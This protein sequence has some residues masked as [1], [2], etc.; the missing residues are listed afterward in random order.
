MRMRKRFSKWSRQSTRMACLLAACGLLYACKDEF[1]L[2]DEKPTWLNSSIY[3]SLQEGI[4][5]SDDGKHLTFNTYLRL[6]ADK[7]VNPENVRPLTDVLN[8][9]GSKTVFVADDEAWDQFFKQNALLPET[10]PWHTATS[11]ENLSVSQK[12]LLIHTSMLNNAIVMENLASSE[13]SN[14]TTPVRG[15]YMRRFTDVELTD[16]VAFD[17]PDKLPHSY[18]GVDKDYWAR[19]REEDKGGIYLVKDNTPSMMLHFTSEHM[20]RNAVTDEDF[21]IIMGRERVT[22]DVHIYDAL[23][24]EK[25]Q[26]CENGYVNVTE[27]VLKPLANMA[28]VIRENGRTNIFSHILDRFCAPFYEPDVTLAYKNVLKARGIEWNDRDSVFVKRYFSDLSY[29]H[30]GW[31]VEPGPDGTV[32]PYMPY[33]DESSKDIIPSLK[34]DPGWNGYYAD[35]RQEKD[36]AAIFAPSDEALWKYFTEGGG[37]QLIETYGDPTK[38]YNSVED[39]Y[40]NIDQIPLGTLYA[41]VG[42]H[43]QRSFVTTVPSKMTKILEPVT[44]DQ[45]FYAEDIDKIDTCLLACNGAVYVMNGIYA[46]GDYTSVTSPAFISTTNNIM[47]WA[48]YNGSK[49]T[50]VEADY[51]GLNYY[52]YLKAMQSEFTFFLPSDE[53]MKYYYDPTSFKST[54]KRLIQFGY[55]NQAFP[56]TSKCINYVPATGVIGRAITGQGAAIS[57]GTGSETTNRL[58]DILESHTI[59]HNID[60]GQDNIRGENEYFLTKNGNAVKVVRDAEGHIVQA[61]GGFQLENQR[62]NITSE[63][64]GIETCNITKAF[65]GLKNGQTYI[66]DAPLI[67]TY[68]SVYSIL[69]NDE[70]YQGKTDEEWYAEDPYA[71][72][73]QLCECDENIVYRCGLVPLKDPKTGQNTSTSERNSGIKKFRIFGDASSGL[74][75][76]DK[77]V[78]FFNNYHYAVFV[79]T[80]EAVQA[81][82]DNG[83]PTWEE[84]AEDDSAMQVV[85]DQLD[86][87]RAVLDAP[88]YVP[89]AADSALYNTLFPQAQKDS[90]MLQAKIT[91]LTNFIRYHFFDNTVFLDK[92][93]ME[94]REF[95]TSSYDNENGLF[96]KAHVKRVKEGGQSV[97][98]VCDD[99]RQLDANGNETSTL[100]HNWIPTT[101]EPNVM[102]RDIIC[103]STP[104]GVPMSTS[105]K[106]ITLDASSTAVIHSIGQTLNHTALVGGR[107]DSQWATTGAAKKYLKRFGVIRDTH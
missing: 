69:T 36:M 5:R 104:V 38:T 88:D 48:I 61:L 54:T 16:S 95:V 45:I 59:V 66:L 14:N 1:K 27:K 4:T 44:Q 29:G 92:M 84:I 107:H 31:G 57:T 41:L 64:P 49:D 81:A 80:N 53:A 20:R 85:T 74:Y 60:S 100:I 50:K 55:K 32:L 103:S 13:A 101:G 70:G 91:Y 40:Q 3:E 43:M 52:A 86:S 15:E 12:K 19:F 24:V 9:T 21:A 82:I 22:S 10:D 28:E 72:F 37:L 26:V 23:L 73:F 56:I 67:P 34:F 89:T 75:G 96:C 99:A 97:L 18:S 71:K 105:S 8:R 90:V 62:Q 77:N 6:L 42:N 51:M 17:T 39:L 63:H 98:Y 83:L 30:G 79:P 93:A 87:L 68:R 65:E 25:D 7:D 58:K 94:E 33:K 106:K 2:D 46:P 76:L 11:Y 47:K 35:V 78:Q 102:A